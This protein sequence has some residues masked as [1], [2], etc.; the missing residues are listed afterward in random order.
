MDDLDGKRVLLAI[1]LRFLESPGEVP[2]VDIQRSLKELGEYCGVDRSYIFTFNETLE[3]MSNTY[4]W[5]AK[6]IEPQIGKLQHCPVDVAPWWVD[7]LLSEGE[8][9]ISRVCAMPKEAAAERR[10][11]EDQGIQSLLVAG[12]RRNGCLAGF[13]GFD[14][15]RQECG[16]TPEVVD[17]M[18]TVADLFAVVLCRD[19]GVIENHGRSVDPVAGLS[20]A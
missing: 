19:R 10:V 11:L 12:F 16:W 9:V 15:V 13:I 18:H 17:L 8:I 6:G 7:A 3:T 1:A 4:E 20:L 14:S 2:S 5:C